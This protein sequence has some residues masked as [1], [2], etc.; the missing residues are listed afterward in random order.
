MPSPFPGMDP[1][2]ESPSIWQDF[3]HSFIDEMRATLVPK[4]RPKYAVHIER[5][6]CISEPTIEE[7]RVRPDLTIAE[8]QGQGVE[9]ESQ[10]SAVTTAVLVPLPEPQEVYHYFLEIREVATQKVITIVEMLSPFNKRA[11]EG[12][13]DYLRKRRMILES[14]VHLVELDLLREGE[15]LPMGKPLPSGHYYAIISRSYKRP[16]AE[17]YAWTIKQPLPTIPIPL[18]RGDEDVMLDLQKVLSAVYDRAG[19]DY[20]LP[21]DRQ[22]ERPLSDD[23]GEGAKQIIAKWREQAR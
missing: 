1:Y 9:P 17:V 15:R 18:K 10:P 7:I 21:Y 5:Y 6:V 23:D 12:R 11:G 2:L 3:H 8:T 4:V 22:P 16:I 20:R 13:E 14:N 19:Y